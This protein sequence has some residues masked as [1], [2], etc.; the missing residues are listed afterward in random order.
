MPVGLISGFLGAGKTTL[1]NRLLDA[2]LLEGAALVINE[3]GEA[4]IDHMLVEAAQEDVVELSGGCVCCTIRSSLSD[5]LLGLMERT[6]PPSRILIET[7]GLADPVPILQVLLGD[8]RVTQCLQFGGM[9]TIVDA[10]HGMQTLER[11]PQARTQAALCD[12]FVLMK[13]DLARPDR[14]LLARLDQLNPQARMIEHDRE[15]VIA[16]ALFAANTP[17]TMPQDASGSATAFRHGDIESVSLVSTQPLSAAAFDAFLRF[18][19]S[20]GA[21]ELLRIKGLV[22]DRDQSEQPLLVQ[23]VRET[24]QPPVRLQRWPGGRREN[25]LVVIGRNL[26]QRA[27]RDQFASLCGQPVS[28]TPDRHAL[29]DNPLAIGGL[30]F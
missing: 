1:I 13:T 28:D 22:L 20:G 5:T 8:P 27:I 11:E 10:V 16:E 3:F 4:G 29:A 30:R 14:A 12:G 9:L 24:L 23:G 15:T 21:G 6:L 7:T 19:L 25:R 17:H 26:A 18:L 2:G